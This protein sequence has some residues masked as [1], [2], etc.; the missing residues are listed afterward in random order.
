MTLAG[1]VDESVE[2]EGFVEVWREGD[3]GGFVLARVEEDELLRAIGPMFSEV[4]ES[5]RYENEAY[6][7][8]H[9]RGFEEIAIVDGFH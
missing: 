1:F 8:Y 9:C 5:E 2:I 4:E 7:L 6:D 3:R